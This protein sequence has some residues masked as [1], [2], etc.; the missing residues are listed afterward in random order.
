MLNS[1]EPVYTSSGQ[2][3]EGYVMVS[4]TDLDAHFKALGQMSDIVHYL[5][6]FISHTDSGGQ[7]KK[8]ELKR[9]REVL[10]VL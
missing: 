6:R 7:D 1:I 3:M 10:G 5:E 4:K 2:K 8:Q 9:L